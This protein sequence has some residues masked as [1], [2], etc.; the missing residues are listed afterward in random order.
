M[1][2]VLHLPHRLTCQARCLPADL[3]LFRRTLV[4]PVT[5][6][7]LA[8]PLTVV[9]LVYPVWGFLADQSWLG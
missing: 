8:W 9:S 3:P 7:Q 2:P 1:I 4:R 6:S 5:L